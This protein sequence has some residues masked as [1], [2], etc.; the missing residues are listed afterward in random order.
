M[1]YEMDTVIY[2]GYAVVLAATGFTVWWQDCKWW[3]KR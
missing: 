3:S 2:I 1:T